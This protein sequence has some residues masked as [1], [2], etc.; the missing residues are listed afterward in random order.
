MSCR[1]SL[2]GIIVSHFALEADVDI[3]G[4][5]KFWEEVCSLDA[6]SVRVKRR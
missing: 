3:E 2:S 1:I 5:G 6:T 4:D